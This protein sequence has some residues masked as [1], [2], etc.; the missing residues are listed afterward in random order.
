MAAMNGAYLSIPWNVQCHGV[1]I[2][3]QKVESASLMTAPMSFNDIENVC[4]WPF[5]GALRAPANAVGAWILDFKRSGSCGDL[6]FFKKLH[7]GFVV[8]FSEVRTDVPKRELSLSVICLSV[9][10]SRMYE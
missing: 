1:L 8:P 2:M 3:R 4:S 6:F 9:P 5:A 10:L 7:R